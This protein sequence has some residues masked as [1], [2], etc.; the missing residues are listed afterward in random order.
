P[1]D[2]RGVLM[3]WKLGRLPLPPRRWIALLAV[4]TV[5]ALFLLLRQ[6]PRFGEEQFE[7]LREGMTEGDVVAMLGS[8]PGGYRPGIWREPDW[9]VSNS[10]TSGFLLKERGRSLWE[11]EELKR[12]DVEEWRRA[13]YPVPA[14]P[15]RVKWRQWW[16]RGCAIDAAFDE[17]GRL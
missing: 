17:R 16:A 7:Q 12:Q 14:P 10:D 2:P 5:L 9:F 13:G 11:L 8:P 4:L 15:G 6:R 3:A 1:T